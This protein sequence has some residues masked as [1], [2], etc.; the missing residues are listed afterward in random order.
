MR[1]RFVRRLVLFSFSLLLMLPAYSLPLQTVLEQAF[2]KSVRMQDLELQ[3]QDALLTLSKSE[4]EDALGITL[5]SGNVSATYDESTNA[6]TFAT[7]GT[8][9]LFSLPN[10][11]N[12]TI[13]VGADTLKWT[14]STSAY[15]IAP[16]AS[17]SH[18]ITYGYTDD[19]RTTL[20]NKSSELFA[21]ST[22]ASSRLSF[23]NSLY[24]L[25][26]NILTNEKNLR[27]TEKS[28]ADQK[29]SL[30]QNLQLQLI[31]EDSLTY[32]DL[33]SKI[34]SLEIQ[35]DGLEATRDLL[36]RQFESTAGFAWEG[37]EDIPLPSLSFKQDPAG[38]SSVQL[39]A[40]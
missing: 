10:D 36:L 29:L 5:T 20:S 39:K 34:S 24:T 30:Q 19:N 25:M 8:E 37:V 38:N 14:P 15:T 22:Y 40:I 28:L 2:A 26:Q 35:R 7:S 9:A 11:G 17:V 31:K 6:Y 3:K 12:T 27:L 4:A 33:Q 32:L 13:S 23:S 1:L 16:S 21:R 18:T